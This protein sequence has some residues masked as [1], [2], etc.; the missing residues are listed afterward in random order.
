MKK[1]FSPF[2][3]MS[4]VLAL[5][6]YTCWQVEFISTTICTVLRKAKTLKKK[7][8]PVRGTSVNCETIEGPPSYANYFMFSL[9]IN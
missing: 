5:T 6:V 2:L 4:A 8:K 3:C 9:F 7:K 1:L